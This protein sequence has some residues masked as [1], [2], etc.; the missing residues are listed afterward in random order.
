[1]DGDIEGIRYLAIARISH[2]DGT[3]SRE[4]SFG[5][6]ISLWGETQPGHESWRTRL[7]SDRRTALTRLVDGRNYVIRGKGFLHREVG[8]LEVN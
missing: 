5:T 8:R 1:M 3:R 7:S 4:V 2:E 6:V